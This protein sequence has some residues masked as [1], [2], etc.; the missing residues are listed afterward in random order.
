VRQS[1]LGVPVD[2]VTLPE[3]LNLVSGWIRDGGT[4]YIVTPNP[5]IVLM[6]K[7]QALLGAIERADLAL[8]DGVGVVWAARRLGQPV[9]ERVAGSDLTEALLELGDKEHYRFYF[10]GAKPCVAAE[11]A[12]LSQEKHPGIVIAGARDGYFTSAEEPAVAAAIRAA[13]PD[14]LLVGLG[15]PKQEL[16]LA[17]WSAECGAKVGLGIGGVIDVLAGIKI[18]PPVWVRRIGFEWLYYLVRQPSRARRM[19]A[20]PRFVLTV[21]A[22][23]R[24]GR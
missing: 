1:I 4:H 12:R 13:R 17:R 24:R 21:L 7:D 23:G 22:A 2:A 14:V 11:A 16:W 20:L 18:R 6:G 19:L 10:F 5:E 9:P 8:A 3:V 15:A